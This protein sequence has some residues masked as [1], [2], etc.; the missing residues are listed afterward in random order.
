M[1]SYDI[2]LDYTKQT[3]IVDYC[4]LGASLLSFFSQE[5]FINIKCWIPN[6]FTESIFIVC[7][8]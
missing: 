8:F 2:L 6:I 1:K 7:S 4:L 3:K 5:Q